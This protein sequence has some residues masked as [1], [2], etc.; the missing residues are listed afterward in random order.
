MFS[1]N[2]TTAN[3]AKPGFRHFYSSGKAF[4]N[5]HFTSQPQG[6]R[7][8]T[9]CLILKTGVSSTHVQQVTKACSSGSKGSDTLSWSLWAS[10]THSTHKYMQAKLLITF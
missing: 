5:D 7:D 1:L 4:S 10:Y 6:W 8:G 2:V 3:E 9:C